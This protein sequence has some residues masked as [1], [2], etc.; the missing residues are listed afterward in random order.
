MYYYNAETE[1]LEFISD[2]SIDVD[3]NAKF[4]FSHA[5]DYLI[6]IGDEE[7][8]KEITD[9]ERDEVPEEAVILDE[10]QEQPLAAKNAKG[11]SSLLI[12][13]LC[14]GFI[15]AIFSGGLIIYWRYKR[16]LKK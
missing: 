15:L 11:K 5:S 9:E 4:M 8:N 16:T 1:N 2:S 6:V 10:K 14:A 13:I 3:G 12:S 7:I